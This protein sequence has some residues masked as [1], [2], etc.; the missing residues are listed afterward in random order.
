MVFTSAFYAAGYCY[1]VSEQLRR[2]ALDLGYPQA[3]SPVLSL[4]NRSKAVIMRLLRRFTPKVSLATGS[5]L[6]LSTLY[7]ATAS[8]CNLQEPQKGY[9]LLLG[10]EGAYW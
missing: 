3:A 10:H 8:S 9:H 4:W 1:Y 6:I 2:R 7:L 5:L